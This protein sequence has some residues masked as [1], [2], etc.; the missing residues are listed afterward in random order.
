[1]PHQTS[2][3]TKAPTKAPTK[4]PTKAPTNSPTKAPTTSSPVSKQPT[5]SLVTKSPVSSQPT[6]KPSTLSPTASPTVTRTVV[7]AQIRFINFAEADLPA[8]DSPKELELKES[9]ASS[10]ASALNIDKKR[11]RILR[12]WMGD[13]SNRRRLTGSSTLNVEFEVIVDETVGKQGV[14]EEIEQSID[15]GS[16]IADLEQSSSG[17]SFDG[18]GVEEVRSERCGSS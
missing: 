5:S 14:V 7:Q 1:M 11:V 9:L 6:S 13:D 8:T 3:P 10:V 4:S 16:L 17:S 12:I 2:S 15:D 18:V